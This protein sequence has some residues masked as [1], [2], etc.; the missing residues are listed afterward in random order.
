[1]QGYRQDQIEF[2]LVPEPPISVEHQPAQKSGN[3]DFPRVFEPVDDGHQLLIIGYRCPR[4]SEFFGLRNAISAKMI[5]A[6][7]T[8]KHNSATAAKRR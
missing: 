7:T 5:L 3:L 6:L 1:M 4:D 8:F 2:F